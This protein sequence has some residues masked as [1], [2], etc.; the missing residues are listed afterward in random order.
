MKKLSA[1]GMKALKVV[2][3]ICAIAWFGSAISMNLLRQLVEV[4]DAAG[5]YWMA[6]ILE[7]IDMKILVPGAI[8]CLLTVI[9]YG[10]HQLGLFQAQMAHG[11]MGAHPLHD[12]FRHILYGPIGEGECVNRQSYH[13]RKRRCGAILAECFGKRLCRSAPDSIF[14]HRYHRICI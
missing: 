11:E 7:A 14:D 6:E 1:K 9:V 13:G 3:L 10:A 8:G 4:E 12:S 2:H 5:M